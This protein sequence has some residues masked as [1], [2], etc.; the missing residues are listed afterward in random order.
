MNLNSVQ[1]S[2]AIA[3]IT[4]ANRLSSS[5]KAE[6]ALESLSQLEARGGEFTPG[7]RI[8]L[9][10]SE[11]LGGMYGGYSSKGTGSS[12]PSNRNSRG[13]SSSGSQSPRRPRKALGEFIFGSWNDAGPSRQLEETYE[14]AAFNRMLEESQ[15]KSEDILSRLA[16]SE[17]G[18]GMY[19]QHRPASY[20]NARAHLSET[21]VQ[22]EDGFWV[23]RQGS[24][25]SA[26]ST[27]WS[28][29]ASSPARNERS[30]T[31]SERPGYQMS[32]SG[33][34]SE[35]GI[36]S[37]APASEPSSHESLPLVSRSSTTIP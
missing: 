10:D 35:E 9:T 28:I 19:S 15:E 33:R 29:A 21:H 36:S 4:V 30:G 24:R 37:S 11:L 23:A 3:K 18:P 17:R 20:P 14:R 16:I 32:R 2:I 22:D 27:H 25:R 13:N 34:R 6:R 8:R 7:S 31:S 26:S 5:S 1:Q 12:I